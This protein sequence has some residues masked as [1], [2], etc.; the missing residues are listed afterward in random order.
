MDE[1]LV[2]C[3]LYLDVVGIGTIPFH[4][5][6]KTNLTKIHCSIEIHLPGIY[7]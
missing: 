3:E 2:N 6:N 4:Y 7:L 5:R 1:Y